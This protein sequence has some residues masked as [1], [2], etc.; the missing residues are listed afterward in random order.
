M[1]VKA[2]SAVKKRIFILH[3]RAGTAI[4]V[5]LDLICAVPNV[6][7]FLVTHE[8][9]KEYMEAREERCGFKSILAI[10]IDGEK[11]N[12]DELIDA[13]NPFISPS[14]DVDFIG[15][16]ESTIADCGKLRQHY[17]VQDFDHLS[18]TDKLEMKRVLMNT[19]ISLPKYVAIDER[20]LKDGL[21]LASERIASYIGFPAFA[22]PTNRFGSSGTRRIEDYDELR[23]FLNDEKI[24]ADPY[25]IDEYLSGKLFHCETL[26][27]RGEI[28]FTQP[29]EYAYPLHEV[30]SGKPLLSITLPDEDEMSRRLIRFAESAL[31][32]FPPIKGG[33]T[34]MEIFERPT[35]ELVFLELAYRPPGILASEFYDRSLGVSLKEV[36]GLVQIDA[37]AQINV[38]RKGY[39]VRYACPLPGN[40]RVLLD[41][42]EPDLESDFSIYWDAEVGEHLGMNEGLERFVCRICASDVSY[43]TARRDFE[44]LREYLPYLK[45]F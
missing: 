20:T 17:G 44:R 26:F 9:L 29:C 30:K 21:A 13:V 4:G 6:E 31:R 40:P 1:V 43:A 45:S 42:H 14:I 28:V 7:Y 34:H 36:H 39:A 24:G 35:G 15:F 23:K 41:A 38:K 3:Y 33:V 5:D 19:D 18:F 8:I 32:Y 27:C 12:Y 11:A 10:S 2:M 22:K 37:T 25:E 16:G